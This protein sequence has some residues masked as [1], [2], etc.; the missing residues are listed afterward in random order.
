[1]VLMMVIVLKGRMMM[2]AVTV[3]R[4]VHAMIGGVGAVRRAVGRRAVGIGRAD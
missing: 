4:V 1:M 2:M 3:D